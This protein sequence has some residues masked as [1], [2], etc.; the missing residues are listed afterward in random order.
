M[1]L[2]GDVDEGETGAIGVLLAAVDGVQPVG[3][4]A[5]R[6]GVEVAED[7]FR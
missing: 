6:G 2:V 7:L 4:A 5:R 3:V 1:G